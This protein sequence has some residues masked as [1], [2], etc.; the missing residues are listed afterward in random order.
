MCGRQEIAGAPVTTLGPGDEL[1]LAPFGRNRTQTASMRNWGMAE[2]HPL[3]ADWTGPLA[4]PDFSSIEV[5]Q[6][7]SAFALVMQMHIADLDAIADNPET[8]TFL[9][10]VVAFDDAGQPYARLGRLF[11]NLCAADTSPALQQV[12]RTMAPKLAAHR[13]RVA[14]H[15]GVFARIDALHVKKTG[16][17]LDTVQERL[18]DRFHIDFV[19]GGAKLTGD[20]RKRASQIAEELASRQTRFAQNVLADES[21]WFIE[22]RNDDDFAGLPDWLRSAAASAASA[23]GLASGSH[24]ITLSRSLVTP[25]LAYSTRR[26]LRET[27][28]KAWIRRGENGDANDNRS[29]IS[30]IL[31]LRLELARLHGYN[32]FT[33]YQLTDTMAKNPAAVDELLQQVWT[34]ARSSAIAEYEELTALARAAGVPELA[35]WD[36]HHYAE[37]IRNTK[38]LLDDDEVKPYFSLDAMLAAALDCATRLFGLHFTERPDLPTYHPDVR[39]FEVRN[40]HNELCGV[41]LS[42]NFARPSKRSGAW[43]SSYRLRSFDTALVGTD[44]GVPIV[45]NHNNFSKAATGSPTLLSLDD[46]RTLFHEFG[47]GLHALLSASPYKRLAG[48]AVLR[49]FIELPSQLFEHW[50][51]EPEVL[52]RHA[53][54]VETGAVIPDELIERLRKSEHFNQGFATVEYVASALVDLALHQLTDLES[55]DVGDFERATLSELGMP[56]AMVMRHRPTHFS[57]LFS[58]EYYASSYYVY[59]WAEVLDADAFDAFTEADDPFDR[60]TAQKLQT[61]IYSSGNT[62]EPGEAYRSFRGRDAG[63]EPLLRGRGLIS[64]VAN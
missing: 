27:A 12:E 2:T 59:M 54:H 36:W 62:I 32:T 38:Y 31:A 50:V 45:A 13:S 6:F 34:P 44:A 41:F 14:M 58:S 33:D 57:H 46:T 15:E 20:D 22:L 10:T 11:S 9:N 43:M 5:G 30:E 3:L 24:V 7:E 35:G 17:A 26:D 28:W 47:H 23:L 52:R 19:Q 42:D 49:D 39:V 53:R 16:L 21:S 60:A 4:L 64:T 61:F 55:F 37:K 48:T 18:L 56:P 63:I 40:A 8:P 51:L 1:P 29:L 25:F